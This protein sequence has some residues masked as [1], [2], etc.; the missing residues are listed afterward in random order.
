M[1]HRY[2]GLRMKNIIL[3]WNNFYHISHGKHFI[4]NI[5]KSFGSN[6]IASFIVMQ[7]QGID[8]SGFIWELTFEIYI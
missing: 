7:R 5:V 4:Y 6:R 2:V 1:L 8:I 3:I